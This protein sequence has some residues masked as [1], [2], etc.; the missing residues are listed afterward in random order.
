MCLLL[1]LGSLR[2]LAMSLNSTVIFCSNVQPRSDTGVTE[3]VS[4]ALQRVSGKCCR[5][6][7]A[8]AENEVQSTRH[9]RGP[10]RRVVPGHKSMH[11]SFQLFTHL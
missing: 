4:A 1:E 7:W 5:L 3:S 9:G 10:R 8:G 11:P 6:H 2:S